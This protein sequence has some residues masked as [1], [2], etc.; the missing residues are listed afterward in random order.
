[1]ILVVGG[2][3]QPD[4]LPKILAAFF[5]KRFLSVILAGFLVGLLQYFGFYREFCPVK[6]NL[7][8]PA[9][10]SFLSENIAKKILLITRF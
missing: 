10:T 3:Y 2:F 9:K 4:F 1:M 6:V 8:N 7:N 5:S